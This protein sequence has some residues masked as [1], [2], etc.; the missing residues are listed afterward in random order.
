MLDSIITIMEDS[1]DSN[2]YNFHL[3]TSKTPPIKYLSELLR[4]LLTEGNLECNEDGIKLLSV[5]PTRTVLVHLKLF[6]SKFEEKNGQVWKTATA[7]A[8][9]SFDPVTEAIV[10][11]QDPQ[12][13]DKI[14]KIQKSIWMR[15]R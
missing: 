15:Q 10:K 5:D 11:Y 2:N 12:A 14:C 13:A 1:T 6:A 8:Y 4:D 7:N 3:W 9:D